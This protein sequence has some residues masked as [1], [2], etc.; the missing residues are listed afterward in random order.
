MMKRLTCSIVGLMLV[1]VSLC[2]SVKTVEP[3]IDTTR[4]LR[5]PLSGWVMYLSRGWDGDFWE[6]TGYDEIQAVGGR[7]LKVSDYASVA[8]VRTSWSSMEPEEGKYFW[9]DP[10]SRISRLL[11]SAQSRGL[12]LAFRIVVDGRDQGQ[13]T[14]LYVRDAGAEGFETKIGHGMCFTAYADDP[15]FQEKYAKFITALADRFNDAD[16]VEFIDA[17]GLGKWGEGHAVVYKDPANKQAVFDWITDLYSKTFTK[18]PLFVHYHRLIGDANKDSW[19]PVAPESYGML[20]SAI[21]KGYSLRHDAFGMTGYYQKWEEDFAK[22]HN[23]K[24]PIIMEGGWITGAH[25]R[26]WIDPSRRYRE[27][28]PEDVREG[29]YEI[30]EYTHV[31]MMDL[32]AGNET[33]SWFMTPDPQNP[34]R[35]LV[36]K[37]ITH[38]GY[39][40]YPSRISFENKSSKGGTLSIS[41][42]WENMGWG[43]CPTNIPQME[44]RYKVAFALLD[45]NGDVVFI[46][47][48]E[49][50]DLSKWI[51][52]NATDYDYKMPLAEVVRGRY[53]LAVAL[54]DVWR[55]SAPAIEMAVQ[56]SLLT[57]SGWLK[58]G[59]VRIR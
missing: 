37:V 28:H 54:V 25:H 16:E 48:D 51:K 17:Y 44:Q 27:G 38:G 21:A 43:Y 35:S 34:S 47:V 4:V 36:E 53:T 6:K 12:K 10:D 20:E 26:Y 58:L 46:S 19:G 13:N 39:R 50:S 29:E 18:V 5:N 1:C 2:A 22:S 14:P 33:H 23:F 11:R 42:R 24:L 31:N 56:T 49:A 55:G 3:E 45:G 41:H 9:T 15:V 52:G 32:R 30:S 57:D 59:Q 7:T 8:Y 40:L